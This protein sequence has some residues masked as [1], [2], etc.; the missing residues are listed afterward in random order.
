ML[1]IILNNNNNNKTPNHS[2]FPTKRDFCALPRC[3]PGAAERE[4][5]GEGTGYPA[6]GQRAAGSAAFPGPLLPSPGSA[7]DRCSAPRP[8]TARAPPAGRDA[9]A[10]R[11]CPA[12]GRRRGK[13]ITTTPPRPQQ[14]AGGGGKVGF[15]FFDAAGRGGISDFQPY[16]FHP[17][18][19]MQ[20]AHQWGG[21]SPSPLPSPSPLLPAP[22]CLGLPWH[23]ASLTAGKP[24]SGPTYDTQV[25]NAPSLGGVK[26]LPPTPPQPAP[27]HMLAS[28]AVQLRGGP[29]A[30]GPPGTSPSLGPLQAVGT[31]W[32]HSWS[33][34]DKSLSFQ[35]YPETRRLGQEG[36]FFLGRSFWVG[37]LP[38]REG[39]VWATLLQ[40]QM[41]LGLQDRSVNSA[42]PLF[43]TKRF[44]D[45]WSCRQLWPRSWQ[46]KLQQES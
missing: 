42:D 32:A 21:R 19:V 39:S 23:P 14:G 38:L 12:A 31:R 33:F 9:G 2:R 25:I 16:F 30:S 37:F 44:E 8:G 7:A 40:G 5:G 15:S 10:A 3:Q 36:W 27:S 46:T 1:L 6:A 28:P 34:L 18:R 24:K 41:G 22:T 29:F 4:R 11:P 35:R 13:G 45:S 20:W 43:Y 26:L 17:H